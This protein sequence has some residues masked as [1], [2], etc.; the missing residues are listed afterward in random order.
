MSSDKEQEYE[1]ESILE[2]R[3]RNDKVQYKVKWLGYSEDEATW[4]EASNLEGCKDLIDDFEKNGRKA[5][6]IVSRIVHVKYDP[7]DKE[8]VYTCLN[9][10]EEMKDLPSHILKMNNKQ[11]MIDFLEN[12]VPKEDHEPKKKTPGK[13]KESANE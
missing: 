6:F 9:R 1:V 5:P 4:E 7:D 13:K 12:M 3:M 10:H 8:Y 2:K 11:L